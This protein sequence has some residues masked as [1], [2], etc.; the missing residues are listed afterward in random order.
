MCAYMSV[1]TRIMHTSLYLSLHAHIQLHVHIYIWY[2]YYIYNYIYMYM[3]DPYRMYVWPA[4]SHRASNFL[5]VFWWHSNSWCMCRWKNSNRPYVQVIEGRGAISFWLWKRLKSQIWTSRQS[6]SSLFDL[7]RGAKSLRICDSNRGIKTLDAPSDEPHWS[8]R[9]LRSQRVSVIKSCR[10]LL[11][12]ECSYLWM[13]PLS[14]W[15]CPKMVDNV[16]YSK[17]ATRAWKMMVSNW[18]LE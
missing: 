4:T 7:L 6:L 1:Y 12:D 8:T 14:I 11:C 18:I 15:V 2:M 16:A 9:S 17:A 10:Q 3:C 5:W 13:L